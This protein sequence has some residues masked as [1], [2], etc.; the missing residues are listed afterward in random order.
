MDVRQITSGSTEFV[1][2]ICFEILLYMIH[3]FCGHYGCNI[4]G[5]SRVIVKIK[6]VCFDRAIDFPVIKPSV[7][8]T[9]IKRGALPLS[10]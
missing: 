1:N 10:L 5:P 9:A 4:G 8:L 3:C 7:L 2:V 6:T